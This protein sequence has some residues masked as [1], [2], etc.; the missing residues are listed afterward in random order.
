VQLTSFN[1][2]LLQKS[3]ENGTFGCRFFMRRSTLLALSSLGIA[4]SLLGCATAK[5][6]P[7]S[8]KLTAAIKPARLEPGQTVGLIAPSGFV[9]TASV[10]RYVNNLQTLG[11]KVVLAKNLMSRWGG[12][13][14]TIQER[15]QDLHAMFLDKNI[16]AIWAARGG[17]GASGLLPYLD[18]E[19]IRNNPKILVG[20]SDV[21]A[22][23]LAIHQRTGL[24]T[25][26]GPVAGSLFSEFTTKYLR[27]VLMNMGPELRLPLAN[28]HTAM[29]QDQP[30]FQLREINGGIATGQLW[31]GNLSIVASLL[32]GG[33]LG[34]NP[35]QVLKDKLLFLEDV[36]EAPYR[37]DRLLTQLAQSQSNGFHSTAGVMLGVFSKIKPP[38]DD[39]TL[40]MHEV[41]DHHFKSV[42]RPAV[43][44][45][46]FGHVP[47]QWTLPIGVNARLD[48]TEQ[49]LTLLESA[50]I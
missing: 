8:A 42:K 33:F 15:V 46:S 10:E 5:P 26:H 43:Y 27:A 35:Q 19:I 13:G 30:H 36:G 28:E 12:Y 18:F 31:G 40:T 14:G 7:N 4:S 39:P 34:S 37:L 32:G 29:A 21:T 17:S 22:L 25:F 47:H 45:Y 16:H 38:D 9:N 24:V 41:F 20:Y 50:V 1:L 11:V 44:G 2:E 3:A 49:T 23:H 48:T 6:W